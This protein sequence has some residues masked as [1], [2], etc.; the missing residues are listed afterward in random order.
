MGHVLPY[1]TEDDGRRLSIPVH[2][3]HGWLDALAGG[4]GAMPAH[5]AGR[6]L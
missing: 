4:A 1:F 5:H 2:H 6:Y 3:E